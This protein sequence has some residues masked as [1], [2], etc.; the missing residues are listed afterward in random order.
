MPPSAISQAATKPGEVCAPLLLEQHKGSVSVDLPWQGSISW[1]WGQH[2]SA[3]G[4]F[5]GVLLRGLAVLPGSRW[6]N[7][8]IG[9]HSR[10]CNVLLPDHA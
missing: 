2:A 5:R 9:I 6:Q 7:S 1:S 3:K 10:Y 8:G 4:V